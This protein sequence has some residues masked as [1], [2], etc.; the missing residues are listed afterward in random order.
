LPPGS[1]VGAYEACFDRVVVPALE[2]FE[3]QL[4]IV[5]CGFDAGAYDPLGRQM[6]TSEA[7]RTLTGK[8][9]AVADAVCDGRIVACHEGGYSAA[10]V[11]FHGL[12]VIEELSGVRTGVVDPFEEILAGLGQQELQPHQDA[13]I[14]QAEALAARV[15]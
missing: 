7:Y 15:R 13:V 12:A 10:T 3:P 6:M 2:A 1:G 8:L 11:P 5:P 4:I 14:K 9:L